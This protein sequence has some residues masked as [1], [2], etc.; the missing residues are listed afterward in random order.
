[1]ADDLNIT[2]NVENMLIGDLEL[3]E[4]AAEGDL[5]AGSLIEF[6]DRIIEEDVRSIPLS[7]MGE[8]NAKIEEAVEA[9]SNPET[10]EGN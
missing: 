8:I 6:L 2:V 10:P 7:R 1:M 5:T 9:A 3:L 4:K